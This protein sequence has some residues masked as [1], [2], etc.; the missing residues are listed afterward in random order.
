MK[1]EA[2]GDAIGIDVLPLNG[3]GSTFQVAVAE[4]AADLQLLADGEGAF[5]T[6]NLQLDNALSRSALY[7]DE[8]E[9]VAQVVHLQ[10]GADVALCLGLRERHSPAVEVGGLL[11]IVVEHLTDDL[12]VAGVAEGV[13]DAFEI[14]VVFVFPTALEGLGVAATALGEAGIAH[15]AVADEHLSS[16]SFHGCLHLWTGLSRDAL[17]TL[18]VVIGADIVGRVCLA[19]SPADE[20]VVGLG[21]G[22]EVMAPLRSFLAALHLCVEPAAADDGRSL[23]EL[24]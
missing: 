18:A 1:D 7:G 14:G 3:E 17:I 23:Q 10:V 24:Q 5:A 2:G 4:G 22:E 8:V 21:E 11:I 16:G 20:F 19:V 15:L 9:D 12:R 13:F 6:H